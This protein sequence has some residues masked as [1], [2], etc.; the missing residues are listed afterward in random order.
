MPSLSPHNDVEASPP[1]VGAWPAHFGNV[2]DE[3]AALKSTC[4]VY[5]RGAR[6]TIQLAGSDRV[7]WLNGMITNNVRDLAEGHGVYA[8]LLNPQGH[9]LGDLTAYNRGEHML[10]DTDQ[11]QV[12]KI[13]ATFDHYIIMD[14]VEVTNVTDRVRTIGL[15]GPNSGIVLKAAGF[16]VPRLTTLQIADLKWQ[17]ADF[18]II[19]G[20]SEAYPSYEIWIA[21]EHAVQMREILRDA[22]ASLVGSDALE[23]YRIALG[24][25][26]YGQDIRERDLPQ[27]TEQQRALNFNKGCYVGQEIVERIRSRGSV[28]RK[29]TGFKIAGPPP[30]PGTKIQVQTKDVGEITSSAVIPAPNGDQTVALGYIRREVGVPG[31]ETEVAGS[32][33]VA[34]ELPFTALLKT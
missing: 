34:T 6:A 14:D 30:A 1:R 25:P 20:E 12:E 33:A 24:V 13:L 11:S 29:F 16:E 3:F 19:R 32:S 2:K 23:L 21:P 31:K 7:R 4:G 9:I 28:H 15:A 18:S 26:R 22:G 10:V 8:F 17:Q 27:E 5:N